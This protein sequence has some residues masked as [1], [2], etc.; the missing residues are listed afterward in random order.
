MLYDVLKI[1][2]NMIVTIA[3]MV[4]PK[5]FEPPYFLEIFNKMKNY[6]DDSY[7]LIIART[8]TSDEITQFGN[9]IINGKKN[10]LILLSDEAGIKNVPFLDELFL[11]FRTYSNSDLYDNKKIFPVPCGYSCGCG[12]YFGNSNWEY[13]DKEK[14]KIL[15]VDRE[16]DI[17][18]SG[19]ISPNRIECIQNL[20]KIKDKFNSIVTLTEGFAKGYKLEEYYSLMQNSKI[21]IVPNG[22]VVPESFRYF[23]AFESNCIVISSFPINTKYH[24]W[25]YNDSPA[26]FLKNWSELSI[27]LISN[28][29]NLNNLKK[30]DILNK[31]YFEDNISTEGVSKYMLNIIKSTI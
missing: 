20:S 16:Y 19:Q 23:E 11:V 17:F 15:L 5:A 24:N 29:L 12:G 13:D 27:E 1:I 28:L 31:K 8:N 25:F 3:P 22:A 30:Y 2:E 4:A 10:I 26:I 21:A 18:Y 9:C 14:D 6:L 7:H